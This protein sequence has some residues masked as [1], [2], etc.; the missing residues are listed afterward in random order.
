LASNS[1]LVLVELAGDGATTGA[2]GY[3]ANGFPL[4][5][6]A[7]DEGGVTLAGHSFSSGYTVISTAP[8]L[9]V[10]DCA[11]AALGQT[12]AA[13]TVTAAT[14]NVTVTTPALAASSVT[15]SK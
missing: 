5:A 6:G 8:D 4:G 14:A 15:P 10:P 12:L 11:D 9:T 3:G 2:H 13:G 1:S 7:T